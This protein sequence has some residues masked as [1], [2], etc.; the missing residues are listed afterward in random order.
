MF[1]KLFWG[2]GFRGGVVLLLD[3]VVSCALL[4]VVKTVCCTGPPIKSQIYYPEHILA[5]GSGKTCYSLVMGSGSFRTDWLEVGIGGGLS[6]TLRPG[7]KCGGLEF[8]FGRGPGT[9][10]TS[11]MSWSHL[12]L[13]CKRDV[14]FSRYPAGHIDSWIAVS[15]WRYGLT[16][17]WHR[18]KNWKMK[19]W[20]W[21]LHLCLK[22]E[23]VLT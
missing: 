16:V 9:R 13:R 15:T 22:I 17:L 23:Q 19:K 12:C 4:S 6:T 8:K 5:Y 20:F 3:L 21:W 14:C 2:I 11:G 10:D 18:S 7:L 1:S